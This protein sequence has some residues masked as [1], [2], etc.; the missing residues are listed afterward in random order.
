MEFEILGDPADGPT[1]D[2]DHEQFAYAGKFVMSSTGKSVVRDDG[3][4]VGAIAFDEDRSE[5][6]TARLR[7]VTVR[8]DRRGEGLGSQLLGFT[9]EY[10]VGSGYDRVLIAANNPIA[11]RAC[12]RAGFEFTG[13][14]TGI[15]ELVLRYAPDT[16][17]DPDRYRQGLAVFRGRDLPEQHRAVLSTDEPP[18]V[19]EL[20]SDDG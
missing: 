6:D 12:Y 20:P 7:Y 5:P 4:I 8:N 16:V 18:A 11:Y 9:A 1:L 17:P 3:T 10:L 13:R 15:A 19:V 2:L 14:E